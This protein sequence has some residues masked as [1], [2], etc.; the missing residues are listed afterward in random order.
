M[1]S[2]PTQVTV[3][4][5]LICTGSGLKASNAVF[6]VGPSVLLAVS[7]EAALS[8]EPHAVE[9]S[10]VEKA[11]VTRSVRAGRDEVF[12]TGRSCRGTKRIGSARMLHVTHPSRIV[13]RMPDM[14]PYLGRT[15]DRA[16]LRLLLGAAAVGAG[17][18][19][20]A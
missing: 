2:P 9:R 10:R 5:F 17:V 3:W 6:T 8:D 19:H 16:A 11:A 12:T 14:S 15:T 18:I 13:L 7:A 1:L 20:L 4:P